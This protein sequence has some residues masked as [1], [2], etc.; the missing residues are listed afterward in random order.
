MKFF[1]SSTFSIKM[2]PND[3]NWFKWKLDNNYVS[4]MDCLFMMSS[5]W[6]LTKFILM[7]NSHGLESYVKIDFFFYQKSEDNFSYI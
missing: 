5:H 4:L 1:S 2:N 3:S 6:C 7:T